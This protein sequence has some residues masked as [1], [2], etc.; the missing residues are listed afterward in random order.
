[1]TV[2]LHDLGEC[3]EVAVTRYA[4]DGSTVLSDK[5]QTGLNPDA[6]M[7]FSP[8]PRS[9]RRT[10]GR[11]ALRLLKVTR[12]R[13]NKEDAMQRFTPIRVNCVAMSMAF[14]A[15]ST[16]AASTTWR[17]RRRT[18]NR[19]MGLLSLVVLSGVCVTPWTARAVERTWLGVT[20]VFSNKVNWTTATVPGGNDIAVFDAATPN[21]PVITYSLSGNPGS[22]S[23][24]IDFRTAGWT[25]GEINGPH[26]FTIPV[27][28]FKSAGAGTNIIAISKLINRAVDTWTVGAGNVLRI[29]S[30]ILTSQG[31]GR[32]ITKDGDGTLELN[33]TTFVGP[34]TLN[35]GRVEQMVVPTTHPTLIVNGGIYDFN[36]TTQ[37]LGTLIL[38]GG[39]IE[40]VGGTLNLT[41]STYSFTNTPASTTSEIRCGVLLGIPVS[42]FNAQR[43]F[44]IRD[45][46]A[47]VDVLISG[48]MASA[49]T[50]IGVTKSGAGLLK[51]TGTNTYE[52]LTQV[53]GGTLLVD[54]KHSSTVA[55]SYTV[56]DGTAAATL[57][58]KG[59]FKLT[60][61]ASKLTV[62]N[63]ATLAPGSNVSASNASSAPGILTVDG[64]AQTTGQTVMFESGST[65]A[66]QLQGTTVGTQHDQLAVTGTVGLGGTLSIELGYAAQKGQT[67]TLIANDSTDAVVGAFSNAG[68]LTATYVGREYGFTVSNVGGTGNDVVLTVSS[69]PPRGTILIFR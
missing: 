46:A 12:Q 33:A 41:A 18:S 63:A 57:G 10:L 6:M 3:P 42:G 53:Y 50:G 32:S 51:F 28:G 29:T 67:F 21:Q 2:H 45:G 56:G 15:I 35:A 49:R 5:A 36:A 39:V 47:A 61:N 1:M 13:N 48:P 52:A 34:F 31:S 19:W 8:R 20:D 55:N 66:V 26:E 17:N 43:I 27:G 11:P 16:Q 23:T 68:S 9:K 30:P 59:S 60:T 65:F 54:G 7:P 22:P 38:G 25:L 44:Y 40:G 14:A 69:V 64:L 58:G 62:K 24:G 37:L 4:S